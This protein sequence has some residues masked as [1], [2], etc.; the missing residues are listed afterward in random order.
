MYANKVEWKSSR[1]VEW[2]SLTNSSTKR[3][4][5]QIIDL[6]SSNDGLVIDEEEEEEEECLLYFLD[7]PPTGTF[8]KDPP[9]VQALLQAHNLKQSQ[10]WF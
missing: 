5:P 9:T 6:R 3:E 2:E 10:I 4:T 8:L 1:E 7:P